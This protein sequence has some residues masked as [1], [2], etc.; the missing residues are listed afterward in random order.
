MSERKPSRAKARRHHAEADIALADLPPHPT[1]ST[2]AFAVVERLDADTCGVMAGIAGDLELVSALHDCEP[3]R[4]WLEAARACPV[5]EQFALQLPTSAA[6]AAAAAFDAAVDALPPRIDDAT[7]DQLAAEYANIYLRYLYRASPS[8]SV[9]LDDDHLE[10]Q[11]PMFAVRS[12]YRRHNLTST[13]WARRPDDHIVVELRFVAHLFA[14]A[15]THDDLAEAA[16]FMDEHLL[17]WIKLFTRRIA[18]ETPSDY[19]AAS[20]LLTEAYLEGLRDLLADAGLPRL[21]PAPEIAR[22]ATARIPTCA[23]EAPHA[24][25]AGPGW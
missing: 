6:K 16:R 7:L 20:V 8:E 10:C 22:K 17:R 14:N 5:A 15:R 18:T 2:A 21:E 11:Q 25:G 12:W 23:D 9:W 1:G 3:S 13:D 24:P 4:E 19:F